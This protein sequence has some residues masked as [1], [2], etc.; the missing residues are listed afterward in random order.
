MRQRLTCGVE[1]ATEGFSN[2]WE[3]GGVG[4]GADYG[5]SETGTSKMLGF[6]RES[7]R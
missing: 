4:N 2:Y 6:G 5:V 3:G 1:A 7:P